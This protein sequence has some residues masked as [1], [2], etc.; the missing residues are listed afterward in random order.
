MS[1]APVSDSRLLVTGVT[2]LVGSHVAARAIQE[3]IPTRVLIRPG[4]SPDC[5]P[6]ADRLEVV[7]GDLT[8][9]DSLVPTVAGVTRI[10]HCAAKVGDWGPVQDYRRVNVDGLRHLLD[11]ALSAGTLR[12][13][14]QISSLGV[15]EARDHYGTDESEPTHK[16]GIDSYTLTKIE[17]EELLQTYIRDQQLSALILRP[18]FIYG[19]R[20]RTVLPKLL[21]RLRQGTFAYLG[22]G[23]QLL[24]NTFVENL[25]QAVF[26]SLDRS[27]LQGRA[28]N[29]TDDRLVTRHEFISTICRHAGIEPPTRHVPLPVAKTL[30]TVMEAVAR[31]MGKREAPL[32]SQARIKFLG[33]NLDFSIDDARMELGY[34]P[35]IDFQEGMARTIEWTKQAG[36]VK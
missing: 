33:R 10:V 6:E 29:I 20:D 24:N 35:R 21:T 18:G 8:D 7:E 13:F 9:A 32:L 4:S 2:G 1:E 17:S 30:A 22:S 26:L 14:V 36:L 23:E 16:S 27:D 15:Y 34:A 3:G 12:Q 5:L 31:L 19:P 11:A 25:V 28:F